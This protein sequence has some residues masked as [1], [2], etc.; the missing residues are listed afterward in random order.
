MECCHI[1][2]NVF[3]VLRKGE[4]RVDAELMDVVLE[5]LDTV[6]SMFGQVRERAEVTPATPSFWRRC[7]AW[8]SRGRRGC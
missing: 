4:R 5:A 1:A 8:P 2:E 7:R 3:D 6:N